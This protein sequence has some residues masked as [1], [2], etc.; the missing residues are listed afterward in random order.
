MP[1]KNIYFNLLNYVIR[2]TFDADVEFSN[3]SN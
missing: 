3:Q 2:L 1:S